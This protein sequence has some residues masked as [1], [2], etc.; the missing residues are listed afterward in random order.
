MGIL[1]ELNLADLNRLYQEA[2]DADREVFAEMRTN[3]LLISGEHF[4]KKA[5]SYLNRLRDRKDVSEEQKLRLTKNFIHKIHR[6]YTNQIVSFAPGVKI[7]PQ[8]QDEM[9]DRKDAELNQSVWTDACDTHRMK[10]KIRNWASDFC[11]VGEV[12]AKIFWNPNKGE[13]KGYAPLVDE[14]T[15]EP[16]L[17]PQTGQPVPDEENPV[18]AGEFEFEK[19]YGFNLL[20][21]AGMTKPMSEA[22]Y[23]GIRKMVDIKYLQGVYSNDPEKLKAIQAS[24]RDEF[25]VFDANK[26]EYERKKDQCL[27]VEWY[28]RPCKEYPKGFFYI[29]T[30]HGILEADELPGGIW[31]IAWA[32][33][34][35]FPTAPRARSIVKQARPH[36]AEINRASSQIALHQITVGDDKLLYQMGTKLSPGGL[37]PGVR[38]IA[39][40]GAQPI[41]LPGRDGSQFAPYVK[42]QIGELYDIV[43]LQE[44][45]QD[46][47]DTSQVDPF[48]MLFRSMRY[49]KKFSVYGEKFEQFLKDICEIYLSLA[50]IHMPDDALIYAIGRNEVINMAEFRKTTKLCYQIKIEEQTDTLETQFG[51]QLSFNHILQ[52]VGNQLSKDDIGKILRQMPFANSE[53]A[54][55]D[56]TMDYDNAENMLLALDRGE[57]VGIT[58]YDNFDYLLKRVVHRMMKADFKLLDPQVQQNYMSIKQEIEQALEQQAQKIMAAKNEFIPVGGALVATDLYIQPNGD[59]SKAAKRARI[60]YQALDW[61]VHKLEEQGM[62]LDKMEQMNQGALAEMADQIMS[63]K[64]PNMKALQGGGGNLNSTSAMGSPSVQGA[65]AASPIGIST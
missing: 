44:E 39:Y 29:H 53:E 36:Q 35:E 63:A 13:F 60:P 59:A 22:P 34:D 30:E 54:F 28:F 2:E 48:A 31:P 43:M 64:K 23:L 32:G 19:I 52:Y 50:K 14:V 33:F 12:G 62:T 45:M 24:G 5:S 57:Q 6:I 27:V 16:V 18:L 25:I 49:Q 9:Q 4:Y 55:S 37:L 10:E 1:K 11:G 40:Q 8:R 15:G 46:R 41:I 7:V 61:L 42:D 51:K 3:V 20:R 56:L 58:P 21:P 65:P 17:D 38:G 47:Q 26:A